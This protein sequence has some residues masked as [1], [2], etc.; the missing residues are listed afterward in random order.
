[1]FVILIHNIFDRPVLVVWYK[2][3]RH[4]CSKN[5]YLK[6]WREIAT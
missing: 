1:M 6:S 5:D 3:K 2:K 4:L